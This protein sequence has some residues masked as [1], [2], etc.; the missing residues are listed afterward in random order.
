M[1]RKSHPRN[2]GSEAP[3]GVA[4]ADLKGGFTI[5][6][7]DGSWWWST[8]MYLLHGYPDSRPPAVVPSSRLLLA[9]RD[10]AD[11]DGFREA[12]GHLLMDGGMV[13]LHYRIVG[14]DQTRRPVFVMAS[15]R[16]DPDGDVITGV[17]QLERPFAS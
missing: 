1:S 7:T 12:W 17:M 6:L 14:A 16:A 10:P 11:R 13:A 4:E 8:G 9:H 5:N 3:S 15:I 2:L